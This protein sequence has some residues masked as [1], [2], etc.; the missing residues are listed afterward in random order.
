MGSYIEVCLMLLCVTCALGER[1]GCPPSCKCSDILTCPPGSAPALDSCGCGCTVCVQGLGSGCDGFTP[2]DASQNLVCDYKGDPRGQRGVCQVRHEPKSCFHNGNEILHGQ[3]FEIDCKS[4]C[5]CENGNMDC[6]PLCPEPEKPLIP[7]CTEMQLVTVPGECCAQWRCLEEPSGSEDWD[8]PGEVYPDPDDVYTGAETKIRTRRE[9]PDQDTEQ[10]E[11]ELLEETYS[12]KPDT[13]WTPCSR[14]CGFGNS[15]RIVYEKETC[16]PKA[17]KRLCMIRP[18]KGQ[19]PSANYTVLKASNVCSRVMSWSHPIHLR[20]R[21]CLSSRPLLPKFCG[22]CSDGRLCKPSLSHT[23]PVSFQ[24]AQ[25]Q[26]KVTRQVM[27][28]QR[29][30]CGGKRGMRGKKKKEE[31]SEIRPK[32]EITNEVVRY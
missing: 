1:L 12:C 11:E 32:E 25:L 27:W 28:V 26:R 10:D 7:N 29:C 15:L 13:E 14:T 8:E 5:K 3:E 17:E 22:L 9:A 2:C 24:C 30:E 16:I 19:Y 18:C 31:D 6:A 20:F 23:R 4:H 21:D